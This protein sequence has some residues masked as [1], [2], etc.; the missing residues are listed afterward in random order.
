MVK[1]K[2]RTVPELLRPRIVKAIQTPPT[3]QFI[4]GVF[5][6]TPDEYCFAYTIGNKERGLPDLLVIAPK[7]AGWHPVYPEILSILGM[8]QAK[9]GS[10]FT[11]GEFVDFTAKFPAFIIH[12]DHPSTKSEYTVQAG[13]Y[14][15]TEDYKVLQVLLPDHNGIYPTDKRCEE[16]VPILRGSSIQ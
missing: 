15:R 4:Q 5:A 14:Y 2:R 10:P 13:Q 16:V 8:I 9:K 1:I 6:T 12:A 7:G 11:E 3:H